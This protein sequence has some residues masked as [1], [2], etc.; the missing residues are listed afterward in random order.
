MRIVRV[1]LLIVVILVIGVE[2]A[3]AQ[4]P[5]DIKAIMRVEE[6]E[7]RESIEVGP[8]VSVAILRYPVAQ[9]WVV[10]VIHMIGVN[11]WSFGDKDIELIVRDR[12]NSQG[13]L[14]SRHVVYERK[15]KI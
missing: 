10:T 12:Y 6:L 15:V 4:I 11:L 8:L 9:L 3:G 2:V 1:I 5:I 7:L 13:R 14:E